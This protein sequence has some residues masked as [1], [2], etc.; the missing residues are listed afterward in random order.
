MESALQLF[1]Y[2]ILTFLAIIVPFLGILLSIFQEGISKLTIQ[3]EN[4]K[5]SS[6]KNI[7]DQ[8]KKQGVA[9]KINVQEI[10]QSIKKLKAIK[11]TA[12]TKLSYLN[13]KRQILRLFTIFL[14]S[15][16]GVIS[17]ILIK[18][19]IYYTGVL[20]VVSLIFFFSALYVL[21]KLLGIIIEVKKIIDGD[22]RDMEAKTIELLSLISQPPQV[23]QIQEQYFLK[24]TYLII[25]NKDIKKDGV[26]FTLYTDDKKD[27]DISLINAEK[28]MAKN[29]EVGFMFSRNF[30]IAKSTNYTIYTDKDG[31]QIVRYNVREI[32]GDTTYVFPSL[33]ITPINEGEYVIRVFI[34]AE[35]IE[36]T[37][38][39]VHF[40]IKVA[41]F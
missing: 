38:R 36:P 24:N 39:N 9:K 23:V 2:L 40:K 12:E 31:S 34:K 15:F 25:M 29:V 11:K 3:Y 19:N 1:G 20:I 16:L 17:A 21:W 26:E 13:P 4:E 35:N 27:V 8:L 18:I 32:Q 22:T 6:E 10:E 28:R 5:S 33:I 14:I 7:Q 41:P 30:I 37:Y